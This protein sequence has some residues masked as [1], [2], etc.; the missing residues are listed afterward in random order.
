[1]IDTSVAQN[2]SLLPNT[3]FS[4]LAGE[5]GL[6]TDWFAFS[7]LTCINPSSSHALARSVTIHSLLSLTI[8]VTLE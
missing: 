4:A 6:G 3:T 5:A 8:T 2:Q 7:N 1:M